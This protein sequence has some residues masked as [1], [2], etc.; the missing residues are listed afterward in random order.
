M[1]ALYT[2][3]V[4][5]LILIIFC[6]SSLFVVR[7]AFWTFRQSTAHYRCCNNIYNGVDMLRN[8]SE[9]LTNLL[10]SS[11]IKM[12]MFILRKSRWVLIRFVFYIFFYGLGTL[13]H[14]WLFYKIA[15]MI[16]GN[17]I[18]YNENLRHKICNFT[19]RLLKKNLR[20]NVK[21]A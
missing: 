14:W 9:I 2:I 3:L 19:V 10:S 17:F 20:F 1:P 8:C 4:V 12:S 21:M 13:R 16:N 5:E 6:N 15:T 18:I 7:R 11:W